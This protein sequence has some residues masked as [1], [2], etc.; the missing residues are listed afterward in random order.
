MTIDKNMEIVR[1]FIQKFWIEGN[2][3]YLEQYLTK[4]YVDHAYV[5]SNVQGLKNMALVLH[6]AFPDQMTTEESIVAQDD[7]VIVRLR[8]TGTHQGNFRGTEATQNRVDVKLY[9]EYRL[10]NDKI[11]EHWALFDTAS[12]FRQIGAELHQQPACQIKNK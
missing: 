9:R 10:H 7:R 8:M 12:L 3:D 11:A 1:A 5:P 4:D 2:H 6:T